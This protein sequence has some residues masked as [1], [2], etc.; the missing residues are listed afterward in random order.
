[1]S[2]WQPIDSAPTDWSRDVDLWVMWNGLGQRITDC[3]ASLANGKPD[4]HMRC[5]EKG[6][7]RVSGTATHWMER[8]A[9]PSMASTGAEH[10]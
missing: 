5:D 4:W 8:P 2:E 6:W 10:G 1:M 3:R 9:P 7:R